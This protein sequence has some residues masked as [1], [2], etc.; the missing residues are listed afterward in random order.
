MPKIRKLVKKFK[1][2]HVNS[3]PF[4]FIFRYN[5]RNYPKLTH[6]ELDLPG[7][8]QQTEDTAVF[9]IDNGPLQMDYAESVTP[10]GMVKR[11]AAND[12]EHY[13]GKLSPQK[14]RIIFDYCLY[15]EIQLKKPCYPIVVTDYDY[16]KECEEYDIEGF[17]FRIFFR[18]FN[19]KRIYEILNTL[20][21]KDYN[22]EVLSDAEYLR[23]IYCIIFA[24]K[25]F[26]KD[27]IEKASYLFA[28]IEKIK[29]NHQLDL[30][31]ALKML[32]KY[33]LRIMMKNLRSC[34]T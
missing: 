29:S 30:H 27:V 12:V 34:Y 32:I 22:Q 7:E 23:L 16:G 24:K 3:Q 15:T 10:K 2:E 5:S 17:S 11:D 33:H 20:M 13:T 9:V 31:M 18:I 19:K 28:S 26:A 6:D 8:F 14:I 25:P 4:D 21:D 1:Q